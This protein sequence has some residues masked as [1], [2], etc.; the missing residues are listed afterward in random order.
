MTGDELRLEDRDPYDYASG[1]RIFERP[2]RVSFELFAEQAGHPLYV[3]TAAIT[4]KSPGRWEL[5]QGQTT[6]RLTFRTG[7]HRNIGGANP[8]DPATD[9]PHD[10]IAFRIR[11]LSILPDR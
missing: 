7:P 5:H 8:I 4:P 1:S 2:G 6:G 10:P 3:D 9:R 11:G